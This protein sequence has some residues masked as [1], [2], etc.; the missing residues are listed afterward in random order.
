MHELS[1]KLENL[2]M[3]K[4]TGNFEVTGVKT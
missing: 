2:V 4:I 3:T 1:E